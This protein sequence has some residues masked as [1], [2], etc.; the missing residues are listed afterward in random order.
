MLCYIFDFDE[1]VCMRRCFISPKKFCKWWLGFF[2]LLFYSECHRHH[3]L[4]RFTSWMSNEAW[5]QIICRYRRKMLWKSRQGYCKH[6]HR[7][8]LNRIYHRFCLF[9]QGKHCP[10]FQTSF[11]S[12]HRFKLYLYTYF[13]GFYWISLCQENSNFRKN[14]Y[15]CKYHD[16]FDYFYGCVLWLCWN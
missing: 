13:R 16:Y 1:G 9:H 2:N 14:K 15:F 8:F 6:S 7:S 3:L 12:S 11:Q 4:C 10:N 5:L